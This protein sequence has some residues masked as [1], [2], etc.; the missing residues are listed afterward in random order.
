[1]LLGSS[2]VVMSRAFLRLS[3][4]ETQLFWLAN[5]NYDLLQ[6]HAGEIYA[7]IEKCGFVS[8]IPID[9]YRRS[10]REANTVGALR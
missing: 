10:L 1:M 7:T 5:A 9:N 6:P 3:I 2:E 4:S 8:F